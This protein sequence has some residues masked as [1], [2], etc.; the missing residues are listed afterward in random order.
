MAWQLIMDAWHGTFDKQLTACLLM[1][2]YRSLSLV[3]SMSLSL[4]GRSIGKSQVANTLF[5]RTIPDL[6]AGTRR[7]RVHGH[8]A[9]QQPHGH[10]QLC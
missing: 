8:R 6:Q 3:V 10:G 1:Q 5:D 9:E 4:A 2:I 7:D